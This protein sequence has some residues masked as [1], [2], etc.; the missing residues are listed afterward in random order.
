MPD[1]TTNNDTSRA[2]IQGV[3]NGGQE[4]TVTMQS[5]KYNVEIPKGRFA[6]PED[7]QALLAPPAKSK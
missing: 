6:L 4:F 2:C 7:V 3:T 5:V 1:V